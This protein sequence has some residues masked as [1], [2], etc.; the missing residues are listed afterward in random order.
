MKT[1]QE[2]LES[3]KQLKP[4]VYLNGEKVD[5]ILKTP[6]PKPLLTLWQKYMK[7]LKTQN[8]KT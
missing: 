7:W 8:M 5:S 6:L 4:K 3:L 1:A 2:Y